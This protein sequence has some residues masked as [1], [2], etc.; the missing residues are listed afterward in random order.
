MGWKL[1]LAGFVFA[2][3]GVW[4]E[5][6]PDSI[7]HESAPITTVGGLCLGAGIALGCLDLK[8]WWDDRHYRRLYKDRE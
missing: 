5:M 7:L 6:P 2:A 8:E 1:I 4:L 3:L